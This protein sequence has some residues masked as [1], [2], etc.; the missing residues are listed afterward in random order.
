MAPARPPSRHDDG[1]DGLDYRA[2][3]S[4]VPAPYLVL[5][6]D[7]VICE[8]N[9]AYL[10]ATGR[11]REDLMGRHVF[12]AFPDNPDDPDADGVRNLGAS[13]RRALATGRSDVMALQRY[14]V[15]R[16]DGLFE[17]RWWSPVNTPVLDDEGAVTLVIHRVED[18]TA[19]VHDHPQLD[20]APR[21][22]NDPRRPTAGADLDVD[23]IGAARILQELNQQLRLAHAR[24]REVAVR[25]QRAM[26]PEATESVG[27]RVATRYLPAAKP[28]QVCGD[29]YDVTDV[30]ESC[31][32]VSVGDVVGHGLS[33]A[34][35]MGQLRSAL[36]AATLGAQGPA[37]ALRLLDRFARTV[38]G[39]L[40]TTV[41]QA[42]VDTEA[43]TVSYSS[44]GH[45]PPMLLRP[46]GVVERLDGATDVPLAVQPTAHQRP[47]ATVACPEGSSLVF[48]TDGLVERRHESIDDGLDR[49]A[50]VLAHHA[51]L[52]PDPLVD[53]VLAE[54]DAGDAAFD[55]TAV[56]VLGI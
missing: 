45:L 34:A 12:D 19:Y 9:E 44:A 16:S 31:L 20:A 35:V 38:P 43:R 51:G 21:P 5:T 23:L 6:P 14:D 24:E 30:S 28:L 15:A 47:Q 22:G 11:H 36:I 54:L 29:W 33:S 26:L 42:V 52:A 50:G 56:V 40:A 17:Q 32:G 4:A 2:L 55:D 27:R 39:A 3:F 53:A 8:V 48:F 10:H 1:A 49:L 37:E 13:L 41:V 7:L 25:L 46:D 18:A